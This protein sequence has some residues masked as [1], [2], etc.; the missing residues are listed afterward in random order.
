[1]G[2]WFGMTQEEAAV[3]FN[4]TKKEGLKWC[5]DAKSRY[6]DVA[7]DLY[8]DYFSKQKNT[9]LAISKF[10]DILHI[11][12]FDEKTLFIFLCKKCGPKDGID[13]LMKFFRWNFQNPR[14]MLMITIAD[15]FM[16][17]IRG[18]ISRELMHIEGK[19]L[20]RIAG[21]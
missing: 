6:L 5:E 17:E 11:N 4:T 14:S 10:K 9:M 15:R 19:T 16:K 3:K 18:P 21:I 20:R 12:V 7:C 8:T 13:T 1:M 2:T